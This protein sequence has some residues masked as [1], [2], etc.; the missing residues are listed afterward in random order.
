M[1]DVDL[2]L[3]ELLDGAPVPLQVGEARKAL[4][5]LGAIVELTNETRATA[6]YIPMSWVYIAAPVGCILIGVETLR[7]VARTWAEMRAGRTA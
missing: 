3:L 5:A 1:R 6:T 7:L 2:V 4:D